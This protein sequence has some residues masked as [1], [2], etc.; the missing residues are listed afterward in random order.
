[1]TLVLMLVGVAITFCISKL[2]V[3]VPSYLTPAEIPL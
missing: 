2:N 1:M 3:G